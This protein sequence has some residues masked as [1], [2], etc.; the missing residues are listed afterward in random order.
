MTKTFLK[1]CGLAGFNAMQ[2]GDNPMFQKNI[3]PPSSGLKSKISKQPAQKRVQASFI[4]RLNV[5]PE[6]WTE[7][8][9]NTT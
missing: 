3:L 9:S 5:P 4:W 8:Y 1:H 2:S 6:H 7:L